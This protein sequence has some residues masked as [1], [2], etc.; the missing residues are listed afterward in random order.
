MGQTLKSK[1]PKILHLWKLTWQW[2][3][4]M[5]NRK[6]PFFTRKYI[7]K[8]LLFPAS[9]VTFRGCNP[10]PFCHQTL[11]VIWPD[12]CFSNLGKKAPETQGFLIRGT[13]F[14]KKPQES[15]H[16][17]RD[18]SGKPTPLKD[19]C[20]EFQDNIIFVNRILALE[21][22]PTQ[23]LWT[24]FTNKDAPPKASA[25]KSSCSWVSNVWV[26]PKYSWCHGRLSHFYHSS[27]H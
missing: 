27:L 6:S 19:G 13:W 23:G 18:F 16:R 15:S 1:N 25:A 9:H 21:S 12:G 7:F 26:I 4:P 22:L 10:N 14:P 17:R 2:E 11:P 24:F 3:I 8:W 20:L 5:L